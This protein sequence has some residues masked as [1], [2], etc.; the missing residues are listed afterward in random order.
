MRLCKFP[1]RI[2]ECEYAEVDMS[3]E[4]GR[5]LWAKQAGGVSETKRSEQRS[6]LFRFPGGQVNA[7]MQSGYERGRGSRP[8]RE[9]GRRSVGNCKEQ[10]K[11]ATMQVSR[12]DKRMQVCKSGYECGRGS[13]AAND[14]ALF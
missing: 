3:V 4:G 1:G 14:E 6:R 9:T 10:P 5:A 7:S 12:A 8:V 2:S 13:Q 11:D